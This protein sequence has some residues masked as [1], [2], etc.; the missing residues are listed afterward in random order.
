MGYRFTLL[1]A[2]QSS[3][4]ALPV[5]RP[6]RRG[7]PAPA[8]SARLAPSPPC[9]LQALRRHPILQG[10]PPEHVAKSRALESRSDPDPACSPLGVQPQPI[11]LPPL[12]LSVP[13][14]QA[15]AVT[16]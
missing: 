15:E 4:G 10:L 8:S 14:H 7:L 9:Q 2:R 1:E 13:V 6:H 11:C 5:G 3:G 16:A 12:G